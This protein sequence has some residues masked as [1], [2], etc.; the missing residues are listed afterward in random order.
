MEHLS[1]HERYRATQAEL[2]TLGV[3]VEM[4]S[5]GG[6]AWDCRVRVHQPDGT[7]SERC[8]SRTIDG[9]WEISPPDDDDADQ[10]VLVDD[11]RAFL[12]R[13]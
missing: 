13:A 4:I 6:S 2:V 10:S 3:P 7:E 1:L 9:R 5:P 12:G 11:V 8:V